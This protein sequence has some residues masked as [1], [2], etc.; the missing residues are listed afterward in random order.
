[1]DVAR[2]FIDV[3]IM[4]AIF[5]IRVGKLTGKLAFLTIADCETEA[6]IS[7]KPITFMA[8]IYHSTPSKA[9]QTSTLFPRRIPQAGNVEFPLSTHPIRGV[10]VENSRCGRIETE[11]TL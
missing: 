1:V 5:P 6:V 4:C 7:I 2:A 3:Q 9:M 8:S 11:L 10:E